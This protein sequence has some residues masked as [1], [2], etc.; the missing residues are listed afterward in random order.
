[1]RRFA[2][3]AF[4]TSVIAIACTGDTPPPSAT[5]P[6]LPV[7]APA[8]FVSAAPAEAVARSASLVQ[9][10]PGYRFT[11]RMSMDGIAEISGAGFAIEGVGAVDQARDRSSMSLDLRAMRQMLLASGDATAAE[12]DQFLGDGQI[13]VVQDGSTVYLK[14]PF[15]AQQLHATTPWVAATMPAT[16]PAGAGEPA[17]GGLGSLGMFGGMAGFG[18]AGSPADYFDQ[19][20]T[21]D[22]TVR[23]AGSEVVRGVQTTRYSGSFDMRKLLSAQLTPDQAAQ[24]NSAMPL[25][26]AFRI[27]Y[28]VWIAEDG[29]P[30]RITTRIDFGGL[31]APSSGGAAPGMTFSYELFDYGAPGEIVVPAASQVTVIDPKTLDAL[32]R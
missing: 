10:Q 16:M 27:P 14:M 13:D 6:L 9:E 4:V 28:D 22:P 30:R 18:S 24:L 25:I 12:L 15:L 7:L 19:I 2:L 11:F 32:P 26:D 21:L 5:L 8:P 3:L 31:G 17:L 23:E 1:M 29:L 20:K